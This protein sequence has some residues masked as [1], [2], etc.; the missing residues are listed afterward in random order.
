MNKPHPH[1][2]HADAPRLLAQ[3]QAASPAPLVDATRRRQ[4]LR[5]LGG[6]GLAGSLP[7][8]GCGGGGD[9]DA[10]T[11]TTAATAATGT[12]TTT[13]TST[14]TATGSCSAIPAET[15]GPYPG[16]GTNTAN[17]SVANALTLADIVRSDIRS[18][19][20]GLSGTAAGV[21]LT[22]T[23]TL[24]NS[25]ASCAIL[26]GYAVYLWHCSREGLYSMYSAGVTNQNYLRG[27]QV[28]DAN[29][30]LTFQT[31]FPGCYSG[32]WP[33]IHFEVFRSLAAATSGANDIR[34]S[35]L[36]LPQAVCQQV[37]GSVSGYSASVANLAA[38]SLASDNVF[39]DDGAVLQLATVS[40]DNT[41]GYSAQ[42]TVAVA[43]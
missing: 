5:L 2:W 22:V 41:A 20:G 1:G 6:L 30:Q 35:Q 11:S 18:S 33:H 40:G 38:I 43:G 13:T 17:G 8:L 21:P 24:V 3:L 26:P 32:R 36:A 14:T 15:A 12:T 39:S 34:T 4:A 29:G 7:L 37:Y 9:A 28:S 25:A 27:V 42:L 19:I 16:D 23:L 10:G 31:I